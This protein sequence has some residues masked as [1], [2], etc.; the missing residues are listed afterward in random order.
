MLGHASTVAANTI[1]YGF[2]P[3]FHALPAAHPWCRDLEPN[4]PGYWRCTNVPAIRQHWGLQRHER[5]QRFKA[6]N[7]CLKLGPW[8]SAA[9]GTA[10]RSSLGFGE[11]TPIQLQLVLYPSSLRRWLKESMVVGRSRSTRF[12]VLLVSQ[13]RQWGAPAAPRPWGW[14][15]RVGDQPC[16]SGQPSTA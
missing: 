10:R 8:R 11:L 13:I 2:D 14:P 7:G 9:A 3:L 4:D 6:D 15:S 16:D 5:G 1:C 12:C